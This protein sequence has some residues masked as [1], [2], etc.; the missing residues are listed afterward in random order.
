MGKNLLLQQ[1][2][3]IKKLQQDIEILIQ[4]DSTDLKT[5]A[6]LLKMSKG[7]VNTAEDINETLEK[8]IKTVDELKKL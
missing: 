4:S 1:I 3:V 6:E 7:L 2:E 8:F 5:K